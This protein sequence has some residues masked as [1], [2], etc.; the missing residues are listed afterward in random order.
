MWF[1]VESHRLP[2]CVNRVQ[3][4]WIQLNQGFAGLWQNPQSPMP[5]DVLPSGVLS[6]L[7]GGFPVLTPRKVIQLISAVIA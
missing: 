3:R 4:S 5:Q 2:L 6:T 7:G 1:M